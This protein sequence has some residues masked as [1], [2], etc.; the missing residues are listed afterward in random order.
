M[1]KL[2]VTLLKVFLCGLP[3]VLALAVFPYL[4]SGGAGAHATGYARLLNSLTGLAFAVWMTLCVYLTVR[5]M[6]SGLF[7]DKVI[8]RLTFMRERDEREAILTGRATRTTFLTSLALLMLLFFLSCFQVSFYRVPPE[9]AVDG[10]T[11]VVSLGFGFSL[12]N[13]SRQ[14][15]PEDA[16]Q[17]RDIFSYTGLPVSSTAVILILIAWQIVSYNYSMRRLTKYGG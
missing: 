5:L 9:R 14:D 4:L 3:A 17:K 8:A 12:L 10:R 11:G 1:K 13:H 6:V 15:K 7:R 2:D 16:I